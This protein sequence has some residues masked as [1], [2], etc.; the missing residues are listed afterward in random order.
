MADEHEGKSPRELE[1]EKAAS[2]K[3][4]I[5]FPETT[6]VLL[7]TALAD[8]AEYIPLFGTVLGWFF[9]AGVLIW[10]YFKGMYTARRRA[11][12][13]TLMLL[14]PVLEFITLGAWL[15][16]VNQALAIYIHNKGEKSYIGKLAQR[17]SKR[18]SLSSK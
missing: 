15:E 10:S 8:L 2:E 16:W 1:I 4:I 3:T 12:K 14:G 5:D 17:L 18:K 11:T 7:A 13:I 6:I 9:S